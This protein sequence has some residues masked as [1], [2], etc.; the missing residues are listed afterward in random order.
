MADKVNFKQPT[1]T[2]MSA[3]KIGQQQKIQEKPEVNTEALRSLEDFF[4][5][6]NISVARFL[7][8]LKKNNVTKLQDEDVQHCFSII[9][10]HDPECARILELIYHAASEDSLP[11][12]KSLD[13]ANQA[14]RQ[15]LLK[16]Y[17]I[18]VRPDNDKS[19][20]FSRAAEKL[21]PFIAVKKTDVRAFNLLKA[22]AIWQ[23]RNRNL[24]EA[25]IFRVLIGELLEKKEDLKPP[26]E[27]IPI[28]LALLMRPRNK[29]TLMIDML[30]IAQSGYVRAQRA[31][32]IEQNER[33]QKD[34]ESK[35]AQEYLDEL[36][37]LRRE[38]EIKNVEVAALKAQLATAEDEI[39]RQSE[40]LTQE[41][42]LNVHGQAEIRG[43]LRV[44]L[45]TKLTPLLDTAHEFAELDPP[46][47]NI[48]IERLEIA[49]Q[50]IQG[51]IAWLK[52]SD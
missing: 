20:N 39:A 34:L 18:D 45:E 43:R 44:F 40:I 48:V 31:R 7:S 35:K 33:R 52:S 38:L 22:L 16:H 8:A 26:S 23:S 50:E 49:K 21:K 27:K 24:D 37:Q 14:C 51:E 30:R 15:Q 13:F 5:H 19:E 6:K 17:E 11:A 12:K 41:Q 46:R 25:D 3:K 9:E 1:K 29:I 28:S 32:E 2:V 36:I 4:H 47:K 10:E 42:A